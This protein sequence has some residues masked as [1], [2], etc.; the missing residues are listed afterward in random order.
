MITDSPLTW[1]IVRIPAL[2]AGLTRKIRRRRRTSAAGLS[3]TRTDAAQFRTAQVM[4]T[5]LWWTMP[6][7]STQLY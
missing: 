5:T 3:L 7:I 1:M 6:V 2:A 4:E